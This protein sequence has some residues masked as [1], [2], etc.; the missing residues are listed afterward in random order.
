MKKDILRLCAVAVIV[1]FLV[2]PVA[3]VFAE[4]RA[5]GTATGT[6]GGTGQTPSAAE[7]RAQELRE[8]EL[9]AKREAG[10]ICTTDVK[11]CH[12]GSYVGRVSPRCEFAACP[13][14]K[15]RE[16]NRQAT[17]TKREEVRT[18]TEE[19]KQKREEKQKE[20]R[21][22]R[23]KRIRNEVDRMIR[24]FNAAIERLEKLAGRIESRI[25]KL[26]SEGINTSEAEKHL[27]DARA[28]IATAKDNISK[29]PGLVEEALK[30]EN[31]KS[32][33]ENARQLINGTKESIRA[34]HA[35]L[36]KA[37]NNL[38]PGFNKP[39]ATSTPTTTPQ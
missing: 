28:K 38:K 36:V 8:Q 18:K 3:P 16:E 26:K 7:R 24:R 2:S 30:A 32:A 15:K 6:T 25:A 37:I 29:L 20:Q 13:A 31:I 34:A 11:L 12:D 14:E 22:N 39:R 1:G 17:G 19:L 9:R 5:S 33:F 4:E 10:V 21:E 35:S 27:S 23:I